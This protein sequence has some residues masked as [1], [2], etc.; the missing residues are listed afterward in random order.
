MPS[1]QAPPLHVVTDL[2]DDNIS[3]VHLAKAMG[4]LLDRVG[5]GGLGPLVAACL[6]LATVPT[7]LFL[8]RRVFEQ[9]Q[10]FLRMIVCL[11]GDRPCTRSGQCLS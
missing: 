8:G 1:L 6:T 4:E 10:E 11:L 7:S 5:L 2:I 3:Q 9:A